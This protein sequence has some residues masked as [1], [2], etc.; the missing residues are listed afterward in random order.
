[1]CRENSLI[2]KLAK[3]TILAYSE[4]KLAN[5]F[6]MQ[7]L[8]ERCPNIGCFAVHPGAV[9]TTLGRDYRE[10]HPWLTNV[11][12]WLI[13]SVLKSPFEGNL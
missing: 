2:T 8:A 6:H 9:K 4:S 10:R 13:G 12:L 3:N 5:L 7:S 11:V 1:M